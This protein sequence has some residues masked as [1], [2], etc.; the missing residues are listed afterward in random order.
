MNVSL[1]VELVA[2]TRFLK[3][4]GTGRPL[5]EFV[6]FAGRICYRSMPK[7]GE[8]AS[9]YVM[10]RVCD[11]H[12]S[13]LEHAMATFLVRGIS[14]ACSHQIVR[15]R[16]A[17]YSQESQRYVDASDPDFVVPQAIVESEEATAV[18]SAFL[19]QCSQVY[20]ELREYGIRKEDARF[21]LPNATATTIL[22]SMNFRAFRH[23]IEM[24]CAKD[25]QWEIREVALKMLDELFH[26]CPGVFTDL[27]Q[28]FLID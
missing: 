16:I 28:W 7:G 18:W 9:Q 6:E 22:I 12:G 25:A 20:S 1:G 27:Y 21:V 26:Q 17:S 24:R 11:G 23:F 13:I 2:I 5:D 8:K 14:R 15:H 10:K 4:S 19:G 3:E